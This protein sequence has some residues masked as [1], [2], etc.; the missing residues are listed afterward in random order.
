MKKRIVAFMVALLMF[1]GIL[2]TN[3]MPV[4][5][6]APEETAS[7]QWQD[8]GKFAIG[9]L[10]ASAG[11]P[12]A[13]GEI[14]VNPNNYRDHISTAFTIDSVPEGHRRPQVKVPASS[15]FSV[16]IDNGTSAVGGVKYLWRSGDITGAGAGAY[17]SVFSGTT[18]PVPADSAS[19]AMSLTEGDA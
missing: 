16:S 3:I 15:S 1:V 18:T 7:T 13:G 17:T 19:P 9:H 5:M 6:A 10:G 4:A 8:I 14:P 12:S 11:F 2:P